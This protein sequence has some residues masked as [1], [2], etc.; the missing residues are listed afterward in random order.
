MGE[1]DITVSLSKMRKIIGERMCASLNRTAQFTLT[2]EIC[3]DTMLDFIARQKDKGLQVKFM[4]VLIKVIAEILGGHKILNA[5]ITDDSLVYH[6][7]VNMGVAV[8][9]PE[10]LMVPVLKNADTKSMIQIAQ[11]YEALIPKAKTGKLSYND[12]SEGT[13]TVSNLGMV[14]IDAFTPIVNHPEAAILGV[15]RI[16]ERVILDEKDIPRHSKSIIFSLTV[17]HRIVDGYTGALFLQDL[18][19][20]LTDTERLESVLNAEQVDLK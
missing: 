20:T 17:D 10:G 1:N 11:E 3:V 16:A 9:L 14:G 13:F 2:R 8:A 4:H 19:E 18:A 15:G 12:M 5:S 6:G 7:V